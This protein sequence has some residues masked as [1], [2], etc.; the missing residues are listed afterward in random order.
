M[1]KWTQLV[2][3]AVTG[4]V[5]G[6]PQVNRGTLTG[7]ITDPSGALVPGVKI[8]ATH[9]ETGT[10]SST[11]ATETGNYTLPTLQIGTYRVDFEAPGFK[12][13]VR[14][15]AGLAAGATL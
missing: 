2:L 14:D 9:V 3:F 11:V 8:T 7:V 1:A 4:T 6:W 5:M 13:T 15:Q 12:R 10:S